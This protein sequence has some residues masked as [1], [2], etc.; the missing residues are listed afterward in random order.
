MTAM[1]GVVTRMEGARPHVEIPDLGAG[2]SHGPLDVVVPGT[3]VVGS[4]VLVTTIADRIDDLVVVGVY[5]T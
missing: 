2:Y 3:V 1:R 5:A 4:R